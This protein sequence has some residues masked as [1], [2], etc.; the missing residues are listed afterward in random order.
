MYIKNQTDK[1][2]VYPRKYIYK[3]YANQF[4]I[5]ATYKR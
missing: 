5:L 4:G 2:Y 3:A 1:S